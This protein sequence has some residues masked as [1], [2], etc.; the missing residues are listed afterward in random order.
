[1]EDTLTRVK[2]KKYPFS[3]KEQ[4]ETSLL[5]PGEGWKTNVLSYF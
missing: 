3:Q 4:R 5:Y 1:M 2:N